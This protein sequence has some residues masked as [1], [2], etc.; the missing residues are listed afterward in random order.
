MNFTFGR[1]QVIDGVYSAFGYG[2]ANSIILEGAEGLV[3]VDTTD[4]MF[5]AKKVLNAV[6]EVTKKPIK[7]VVL[8]HHHSDHVGGTE[9]FITCMDQVF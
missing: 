1:S 7:A 9:V 2:G 6:R 5:G 8:T 3:I 4:T